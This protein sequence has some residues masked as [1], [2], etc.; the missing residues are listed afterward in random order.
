LNKISSRGFDSHRAAIEQQE[1]RNPLEDELKIVNTY[2]TD[3]D[4]S[5]SNNHGREQLPDSSS[6]ESVDEGTKRQREI[7]KQ[8]EAV[9]AANMAKVKEY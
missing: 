5:K 6:N 1:S 4:G 7:E 9:K 8:F 3:Y 2:A